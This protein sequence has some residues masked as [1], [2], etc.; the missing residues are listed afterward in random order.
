MKIRNVVS[1]G[2]IG[3]TPKGGWANELN[4]NDSLHTLI[5]VHTDEGHT[6]LGSVF[7]HQDLVAGAL[8]VL[9]DLLV[10]MEF[11]S[12]T[13]ITERLHQA[14]FWMGRG[15]SITHT[16][17]GVNTAL[18]DIFGQVTGMPISRLLGGNYRSKVLPYASLLMDDP[19][20]MVPRLEGYAS[21]G[22][23]AFKIGWGRFGR[24]SAAT[25][26]KIIAAA[27]EAVGPDAVL[28]VD[29]GGSDGFWPHGYKWAINT[30]HMLAEY[31]VAWFEEALSPDDLAGYVELTTHSPVPISGAETLTRR[32][33]FTPF[34]DARAFDIVQPDVTKN[35][36][37]DESMAIG[38]R[39]E[40]AGM[41]LI[42]H[43]WNTAVGLAADLHT[44]AA[45]PRT[46]FVEYCTGSAYIDDIVSGGWSL[47]EQGMLDIP[48]GPGL[49]ITWDREAIAHYTRGASLFI[50]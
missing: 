49:G 25:D 6:G 23:R 8:S 35:G 29:A 13:A 5:A 14:N 7:T 20:I 47:D 19:E 16:I 10:G 39:A 22:F 31:N 15:G 26:R 41:R 24:D 37:I 28:A 11:D 27:R 44:A 30:A 32:Q 42:P 17:S 33:S 3:A 34:I 50:D 36:G 2:L 48:T 43:G 21:E 9:N 18:W 12:P 40:E 38:R 1:A 45:L 46:D 4:P